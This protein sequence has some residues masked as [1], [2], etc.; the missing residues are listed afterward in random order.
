MVRESGMAYMGYDFFNGTTPAFG[1][2]GTYSPLTL[3]E[4]ALRVINQKVSLFLKDRLNS[5]H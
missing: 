2:N 1:K 3:T 4:E 5:M